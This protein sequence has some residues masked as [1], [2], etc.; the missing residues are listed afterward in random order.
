MTTNIIKSKMKKSILALI[1]A[2][3]IV[4]MM[5]LTAFAHCDTMDGPTVADGKKAMESNNVNYVLKWVQPQYEK[6]ITD[7]FNLSMKVKDLSPEAKEISEQYFFS[8]L[9]RLHRAGEGAPFDGL[10]PS[11]T[12]IDEKILAADKSIEV[13]NLSPLENMIE[14]DKMPELKERF[15]KVMAL[16]N[17]DVNNVEAGR[18]YIEAYV[19]FFKFAEGE[20]DETHGTADVHSTADI[21]EVANVAGTHEVE[22]KA[23]TVWI[24]WTLAGLFFATTVIAHVK[25]KHS[26]K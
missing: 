12:P 1:A 17:F 22:G 7:K 6:E 19:K 13:G 21:R 5:P 8:E 23:S 4:V 10:K 16:K 25:H 2:I 14:K 9:V 3:T 15:E 11:G 20:E 18:E 24:P 26:C